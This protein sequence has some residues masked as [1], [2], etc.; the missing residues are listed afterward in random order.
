MGIEPENMA[1]SLAKMDKEAMR[2]LYASAAAP[3]ASRL[4]LVRLP[5]VQNRNQLRS[6][7]AVFA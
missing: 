5:A 3:R 2:Q 1:P 7:L 4:G 6:R